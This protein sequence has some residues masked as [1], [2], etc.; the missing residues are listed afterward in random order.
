MGLPRQAMLK[1]PPNWVGSPES[2]VLTGAAGLDLRN[3]FLRSGSMNC[4]FCGKERP[5]RWTILKYRR[6]HGVGRY[7]T[8]DCAEK[9]MWGPVFRKARVLFIPGVKK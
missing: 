7:C 9:D 1:N 4:W 2:L 3:K 8:K 6:K 5:C